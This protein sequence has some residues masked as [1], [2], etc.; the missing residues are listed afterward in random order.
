MLT[1]R[2]AGIGFLVVMG[3]GVASAADH[4]VLQKDGDFARQSLMIQAGDA[5]LIK[6]EDDVAHSLISKS[7]GLDLNE[8]QQPGDQTRIVFSNEGQWVIRCA[9]HPKAKLTVNVTR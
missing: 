8:L 7:A 1:R 9:I 6:N 3:A 5:V 4:E 2:L